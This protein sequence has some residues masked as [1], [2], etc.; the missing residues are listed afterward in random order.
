MW[1]YEGSAAVAA[2]SCISR[3]K[4]GWVRAV[5]RDGDDTRPIQKVG[6]VLFL[7][8]PITQPYLEIFR[9]LNRMQSSSNRSFVVTTCSAM[10]IK[11]I[12]FYIQNEHPAAEAAAQRWWRNP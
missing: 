7:S 5:G 9:T 12:L 2:A 4:W 11:A 1:H 6:R 3:Q 8:K 10:T